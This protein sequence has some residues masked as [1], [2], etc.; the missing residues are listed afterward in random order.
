[1][2]RVFFFCLPNCLH[3]VFSKYNTLNLFTHNAF[4]TVRIFITKN[5]NS[6]AANIFFMKRKLA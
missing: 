2:I 5:V 6:K 1:M 4:K 3:V